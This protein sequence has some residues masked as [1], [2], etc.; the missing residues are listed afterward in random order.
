MYLVATR[1]LRS[2]WWRKAVRDIV[3][4]GH[5]AHIDPGLRHG[6]NDVGKA[7]AEAFDEHDALVGIGDHFA[8][9]IFAG[10]AEMHGARRELRGDFG[11]RQIGDLDIVEAGDRAAI[12]ARA[13]RL[14]RESIPPA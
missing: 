6:D 3:D 13:T 10:D 1:I 9:E 7:E 12:V 11:G 2:W 8:D 14:D 4:I 5:G